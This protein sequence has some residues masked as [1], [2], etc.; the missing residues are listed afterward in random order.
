MIPRASGL[1][2]CLSIAASAAA[3]TAAAQTVNVRSGE[4]GTFTRLVFDLPDETEWSLNPQ[5]DDAYVLSFGRTG[6]AVDLSRAFDRIDRSRVARLQRGADGVTISLACNCKADGFIFQ[7][8]MLVVDISE[9]S[10]SGDAWAGPAMQALAP[11]P[12]SLPPRGRW[13]EA[14][15]WQPLLPSFSPGDDTARRRR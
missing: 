1:L 15:A 11:P 9:R 4:H 14:S 7:N 5:R 8:R 12:L 2:L 13:L 6:W 3:Q 10:G